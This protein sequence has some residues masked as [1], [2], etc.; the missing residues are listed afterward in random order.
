MLRPT[1]RAVLEMTD[2]S[3]VVATGV[4]AAAVVTGA[5]WLGAET[6]V[7]VGAVAG[8]AFFMLS[9]ADRTIGQRIALFVP[10]SIGTAFGSEAV[11]EYMG[12]QPKAGP[13]V[14]FALGLV[15]V[16]LSSKWIRST[17]TASGRFFA[18]VWRRIT[19][20]NSNDV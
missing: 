1:A 3:A 16:V 9:S 11:V 10:S 12:L 2:Q 17:E 13:V 18:E 4:S 14:A 5:T 8:V 7:W 20:R 6:A 19:G 15:L